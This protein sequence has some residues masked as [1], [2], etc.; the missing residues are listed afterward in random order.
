MAAAEPCFHVSQPMPLLRRWPQ[1][2]GHHSPSGDL[3]GRLVRAGAEHRAADLDQVPEVY[4]AA[5]QLVGLRADGI[6][7]EIDLH[8]PG[9]ILKLCEA[10][11]AHRAQQ[12]H[13]GQPRSTAR[14]PLAALPRIVS[15]CC[16][17]WVR[18][19]RAGNVAA[20]ASRSRWSFARRVWMRGSSSPG[21]GAGS[22]RPVGWQQPHSSCRD[23]LLAHLC[24]PT[25]VGRRA[26]AGEPARGGPGRIG[27]PG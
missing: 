10:R 18:P 12:Q 26:R 9:G 20:P 13:A 27:R 3:Q 21:N 15:A 22:C 11:A 8:A 23:V 19:V 17:E 7:V 4:S 2:L 14:P 24:R 25:G 6:A 5:E 1:R 16:S